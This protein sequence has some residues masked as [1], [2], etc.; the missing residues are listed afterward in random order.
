M[1]LVMREL[2]VGGRCCAGRGW[3]CA[4]GVDSLVLWV[5]AH[6]QLKFCKFNQAAD[7]NDTISCYLGFLLV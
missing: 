6:L 1:L 5:F 2:D 3:W 7:K 4:Y